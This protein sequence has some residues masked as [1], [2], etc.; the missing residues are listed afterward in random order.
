MYKFL[1]IDQVGKHQQPNPRVQFEY[2]E[3]Y[4]YRQML[5]C[6]Q[7][8]NF[9]VFQSMT[10]EVY[11]RRSLRSTLSRRISTSNIQSTSKMFLYS[12]SLLPISFRMKLDI[13]VYLAYIHW[14]SGLARG[15]LCRGAAVIVMANEVLMLS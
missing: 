4:Y 6:S 5:L 10:I 1:I 14:L 13:K 7:C 9:F 11:L 2:I 3:L 8:I 15:I 12:V